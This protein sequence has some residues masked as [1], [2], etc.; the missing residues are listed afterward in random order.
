MLSQSSAHTTVHSFSDTY[1]VTNNVAHYWSLGKNHWSSCMY[2]CC[3]LFTMSHRW[4]GKHLSSYG[5]PHN[6]AHAITEWNSTPSGRS[7]SVLRDTFWNTTGVNL[8]QCKEHLTILV[9]ARVWHLWVWSRICCLAARTET[10]HNNKAPK[11]SWALWKHILIKAV[12]QLSLN[13][14]ICVLAHFPHEHKMPS[15]GR[16]R[17]GFNLSRRAHFTRG[18]LMKVRSKD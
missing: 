10:E 3:S 12:Y 13:K 2:R 1:N 17:G 5:G 18:A 15:C 9:C 11:E 16:D 14:S 7:N 6:W 8:A 4:A